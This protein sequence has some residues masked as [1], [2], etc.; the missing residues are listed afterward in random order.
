LSR[1]AGD[2]VL[3]ASKAGPPY[4]LDGQG[5]RVRYDAAGTARLLR[6][7]TLQSVAPGVF[8]VMLDDGGHVVTKDGAYWQIDLRKLK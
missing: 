2:P 3:V 1:A 4:Y 8:R 6:E 5:R 7:G